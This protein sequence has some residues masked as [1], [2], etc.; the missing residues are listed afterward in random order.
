ML[1]PILI[2]LSGTI[3][4]FLLDDEESKSLSRYVLSGVSDEYMR[5]W[6]RRK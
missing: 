4:E 3:Q 1:P 2:D 5:V 6:E